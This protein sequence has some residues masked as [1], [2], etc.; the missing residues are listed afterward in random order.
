[1]AVEWEENSQG[2]T[3]K[4]MHCIQWQPQPRCR[5]NV[6][7]RQVDL[8]L[9]PLGIALHGGLVDVVPE[10]DQGV[11]APGRLLVDAH[12]HRGQQ[13]HRQQAEFKFG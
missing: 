11:E 5:L 6:G 4:N 3:K 8:L 1:M 10:G 2:I 13:P 12:Q 7:G 9:P